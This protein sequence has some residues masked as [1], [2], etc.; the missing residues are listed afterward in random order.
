MHENAIKEWGVDHLKEI[1]DS[2]PGVR[3]HGF[4]IVTGLIRTTWCQLKCWSRESKDAQISLTSNVPLAPIGGSVR[5]CPQKGSVWT[6][7]TT[8]EPTTEFV[9]PISLPKEMLMQGNSLGNCG[10]RQRSSVSS[11]SLQ[12]PMTKC[13]GKHTF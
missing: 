4:F 9:H 8:Y 5:V 10:V 12:F 13:K 1:M 6:G 3:E 11:K 7:S 2:N